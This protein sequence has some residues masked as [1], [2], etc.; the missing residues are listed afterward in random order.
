MKNHLIQQQQQPFFQQLHPLF[1]K[2]PSLLQ[3]KPFSLAFK[4]LLQ[5]KS[6]QNL[7]PSFKLLL[8]SF[9][10]IKLQRL[11]FLNQ[12]KLS[13]LLLRRLS[14]QWEPLRKKNR[15]ILRLRVSFP[16]RELQRWASL[17]REYCRHFQ[18]LLRAS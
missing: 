17:L 16:L 15:Q 12:Q 1:V 2:L 5:K 4:L 13:L 3:L 6:H 7:Q 8:P 18:I 11:S 10:V 14:L 9:K